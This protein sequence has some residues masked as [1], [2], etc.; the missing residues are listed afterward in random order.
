MKTNFKI[1]WL[2]CAVALL[3]TGI[4]APAQTTSPSNTDSK[5]KWADIKKFSGSDARY[6]ALRKRVEALTKRG[7]APLDLY[8]RNLKKAE[9]GD[10]EALYVVGLTAHKNSLNGTTIWV[11]SKKLLNRAFDLQN[12]V[13]NLPQSYEFLRMRFLLASRVGYNKEII[14]VGRLLLKRWPNDMETEFRFS[15]AF[16]D[17]TRTKSERKAALQYVLRLQKKYPTEKDGVRVQLA[18]IYDRLANMGEDST[19]RDKE[20]AIYEEFLKEFRRRP[21]TPRIKEAIMNT[22]SLLKAARKQKERKS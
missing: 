21:Q 3:V 14:P 19:A 11:E 17:S 4:H 12:K 8:R 7:T 6:A 15:R 13:S 22:S 10:V 16:I 18:S 2:C 5:L 1:T 9:Q 20:I